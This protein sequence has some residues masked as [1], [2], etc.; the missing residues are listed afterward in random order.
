MDVG[1]ALDREREKAETFVLAGLLHH[2]PIPVKRPDWYHQ[3]WFERVTGRAFEQTEALEDSQQFMA[4]LQGRRIGLVLHGH[5]HIPRVDTHDGI[6]VVGC[7]STVGKVQTTIPGTTYMSVN[8]V[9][10]DSERGLISCRL[11]V[12]RLPGAGLVS[13]EPHEAVSRTR[14]LN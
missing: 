7:G 11:R 13:E 6:T 12:E 14:I 10:V 2:H 4:W 3:A 5:K 1:L 8:V 9:T